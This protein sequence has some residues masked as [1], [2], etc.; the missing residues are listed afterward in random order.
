MRKQDNANVKEQL[1]VGQTWFMVDLELLNKLLDTHG[2]VVKSSSKSREGHLDGEGNCEGETC[3]VPFRTH[4]SLWATLCGSTQTG[5]SDVQG[6]RLD[7]YVTA[8]LLQRAC[9][10]R[11]RS[12][13]SVGVA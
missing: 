10:N 13:C 11:R 4:R 12:D 3:R 2:K 1:S 6:G 8:L 7:V 9:T 5:I